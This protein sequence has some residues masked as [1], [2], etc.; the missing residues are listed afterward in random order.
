ML[1]QGLMSS[2]GSSM[3]DAFKTGIDLGKVMSHS[4][5]L[6]P[7]LLH[8]VVSCPPSHQSFASRQNSKSACGDGRTQPALSQQQLSP[9]HA[10][11]FHQCCSC[12]ILSSN[13][14]GAFLGVV[15]KS[16]EI[17]SVCGSGA[18]TMLITGCQ[19]SS[20]ICVC[21]IWPSA[22]HTWAIPSAQSTNWDHGCPGLSRTIYQDRHQAGMWDSTLIIFIIICAILNVVQMHSKSCSACAW[23]KDGRDGMR[24]LRTH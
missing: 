4:V 1:A 24:L 22:S 21:V 23:H 15:L 10:P 18:H 3:I 8:N 13:M 11:I 6:L 16:F 14:H 7:R 19:K 20:S 12:E 17:A 2:E 9:G 5:D